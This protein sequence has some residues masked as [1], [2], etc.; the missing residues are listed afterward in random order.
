[1]GRL[2]DDLLAFSRMGRA[3]I[4]KQQVDLR[5]LVEE[6]RAEVAPQAAGREVYWTIHDLPAVHADPAL[7]R[8]ALINLLSN[9]LKYTGTRER[10]CIEIGTTP[11]ADG[12]IA[13]FIKD[14][15]VGFVMEYAHKLFGVF[16]RLH[17]SN[18]FAGTGI[19]LA[20]VRRIIQRHGGRTWA[21]GEVGVGATFCFSLPTLDVVTT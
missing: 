17:A 6:A 14:N 10:A 11:A 16:Q 7:L 1:M 19:G 21:T 12:E 5:A 20:N 4:T 15:G 8:P 18:E 2:I 3:A 9:A 13:I